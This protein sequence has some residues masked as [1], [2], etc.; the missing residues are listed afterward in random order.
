MIVTFD[1]KELTPDE[2]ALLTSMIEK[3]VGIGTVSIDTAKPAPRVETPA[4]PSPEGKR[5][6]GRPTK[7]EMAAR[8]AAEAAGK[9]ESPK[10][11][12]PTS[13]ATPRVAEA[14]ASAP[15]AE[16]SG[17]ATSAESSTVSA[18]ATLAAPTEAESS[19]LLAPVPAEE[20]RSALLSHN[21]KH[22]LESAVAI[23]DK[24]GI[25]RAGEASGL[26]AEKQHALVAALR[27]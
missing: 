18:P 27:K 3:L 10:D 17:S 21:E 14:S 16:P 13:S 2:G 8:K 5:R 11:D 22:G 26:P 1:T 20:I 15:L 19:T 9:V 24:F 23:L 12:T 7:E 6:P 25:K 4:E